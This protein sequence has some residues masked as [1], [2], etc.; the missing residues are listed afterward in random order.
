MADAEQPIQISYFGAP[1][2]GEIAK[3][4]LTIAG[5]PFT[6]DAFDFAGWKAKKADTQWG[7]CP[8]A[9][10]PDGT[11]VGQSRAM[12]RY[13]AK[14]AGLYPTCAVAAAKADSVYD[15]VE[16][17]LTGMSKLNK[18]D[19]H[20]AR[21]GDWAEDGKTRQ[22][23]MKLDA[24]IAAEG[25][26]GFSIGNCL[27][28]ADLCVFVYATNITS[29]FFDHYP[30]FATAFESME[31]IRAVCN[32]VGGIKAVRDRYASD[33]PGKEHP[34]FKGFI[35]QAT[36]DGPETTLE[37]SSWEEI[38]TDGKPTLTYFAAPGR[39]EILRVLYCMEGKDIEDKM[40]T[41][42]EWGPLKASG[43]IP[44]GG[45]LP[46]L[47]LSDG[48]ILTQSIAI[49]RYAAKMTGMY[50]LDP[51]TAQKADAVQD[52]LKDIGE[53]SYKAKEDPDSVWG[54]GK[55]CTMLMDKLEA[56]IAANGCKFAASD[57]MSY[58]DIGIFL[59]CAALGAN[60]KLEGYA[61]ITEIRN[62][63]LKHES[64][65]PRYK[66]LAKNPAF[67]KIADGAGIDLS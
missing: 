10:L 30:D 51:L 61:K 67:K 15:F 34:P 2:R 41:G 48:T 65:A 35:E 9:T 60:D 55:K 31:N 64:L 50:P 58:A 42:E 46:I 4:C 56:F 1:G 23:F 38:K 16:D 20:A 11:V 24:F 36:L 66:A 43:T 25:K 57:T 54:E 27:S 32:K 14:Q 49:T 17:I 3:L 37:K 7:S 28:L 52:C 22:R 40:I 5:I 44:L 63:V 26:D 62:E 21:K 13:F 39:A 8:Y 33:F 18:E 45:Q 12:S 47:T 29:G 53:A 6:E 19:D 59:I